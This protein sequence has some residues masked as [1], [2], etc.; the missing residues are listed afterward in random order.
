MDQLFAFIAM[1]CIWLAWKAWKRHR[2]S[3]SNLKILRTEDSLKEHD[4]DLHP[5]TP[6]I[7]TGPGRK[8]HA[9]LK[10]NYIDSSGQESSRLI[11]VIRFWESSSHGCEVDAYCHLRNANRTFLASRITLCV[12]N[13]TGEIIDDLLGFLENIYTHSV[14]ASIDRLMNDHRDA[15]RA[16]LYVAKADGQLRKPEKLVISELLIKLSQDPRIQL[17]DTDNLLSNVAIP[18]DK[19]FTRLLTDGAKEWPIEVKQ[20]VRD[21]SEAIVG[22]QKTVHTR[23][24]SALN[25]IDTKLNLSRQ[26]P[27]SE[28]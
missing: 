5:Y 20:L 12:D 16:V 8:A 4:G 9:R 23:E 21:A 2:N 19:Q 3:E 11:N 17:H 22:T 13:T 7:R 26:Y 25:E 27:S 24:R 10:I 1:F 14:D 28:G 18:T 15:I 6:T